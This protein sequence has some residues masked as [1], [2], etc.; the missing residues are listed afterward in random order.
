VSASFLPDFDK[1][2]AL[3][4]IGLMSVIRWY[5][6]DRWFPFLEDTINPGLQLP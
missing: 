3:G 2:D 1:C 6:D 5:G 4:T